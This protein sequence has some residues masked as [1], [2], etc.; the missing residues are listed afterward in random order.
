MKNRR[1]LLVFLF[2]L[3]MLQ[4][5]AQ[6]IPLSVSAILGFSPEKKK[7]IEYN[8][9]FG[10]KAGAHFKNL[11]AGA[12]IFVHGGDEL[13]IRYGSVS[14]LGINGG[15][16]DYEWR[17]KFFMGDVGYAFKIKLTPNL[18]SSLMPYFSM[19]LASIT[20]KSSGVYGT[21]DDLHS[22]KFGIGGGFS[23]SVDVAEHIS[24]GLEYRL[25]PLSNLHADFGDSS[26]GQIEH[27]F[28]TG[29]YYD[30][31]FATVSY[32]F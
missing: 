17:P 5:F 25:Y 32:N 26:K 28:H 12:A 15:R 8:A 7:G 9:G 24:V 22:N 20:V 11:Y 27:G 10:V 3:M 23:Y 19:G 31:V 30:A 1:I 18:S 2:Q 16:Q 29:A 4:T 6:K 13:S 14:G 21:P